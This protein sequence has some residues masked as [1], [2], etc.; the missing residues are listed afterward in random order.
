MNQVKDI[1]VTMDNDTSFTNIPFGYMTYGT[2]GDVWYRTYQPS[3]SINSRKHHV[4]SVM[5]S[6]KISTDCNV[7]AGN[8]S[9]GFGDTT[10]EN[11]IVRQQYISLPY[12]AVSSND[13]AAEKHYYKNTQIKSPY[14]VLFAFA[15][16][17]LNHFLFKGRNNFR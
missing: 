9:F 1:T 15:L 4:S 13:L 11:D 7:K 2:H 10:N 6:S 3:F 12:P 17:R 14:V 5:Q 8:A 16:E